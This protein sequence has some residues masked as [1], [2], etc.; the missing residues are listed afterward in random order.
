[1]NRDVV[2]KNFFNKLREAKRQ[3]NK[4]IRLSLIE[5]DNLGQCV[6]ELLAEYYNKTISIV[7]NQTNTVETNEEVEYTMDGGSF[8]E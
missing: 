3:G 8:K 6:F 7:K 4:D 1:M 2:L 5:M